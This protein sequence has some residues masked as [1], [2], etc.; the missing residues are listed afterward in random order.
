MRILPAPEG[1]S[2][3][4]PVGSEKLT[5][6]QGA[7]CTTVTAMTPRPRKSPPRRRAASPA[8]ATRKPVPAPAPAGPLEALARVGAELAATLD[9]AQVTDRVA[10]AAVEILGAARS[11][12]S[13][14]QPASRGPVFVAPAAPAG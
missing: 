6:P 4:R 11:A 14:L 1:T 12:L 8:A 9:V 7:G 13:R 2:P 10:H 3:G 5:P